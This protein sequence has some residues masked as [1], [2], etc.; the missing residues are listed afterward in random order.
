MAEADT[1]TDPSALRPM[2]SGS[3]ACS[4]PRRRPCGAI[5]PR[6]SFASSGSWAAP[7]RVPDGEFELLN[8]HDNLSD[9]QVPY[10]ERLRALQRAIWNEK[11]IRFEPPRL[12]ETTFQGGK[13]GTV[14]FELFPEG[15]SHPARRDAQRHHQPDRRPGFRRRLELAH[16]RASGEA[17]RARRE[18]TSGRFTPIA[19]G[20][21]G[22]ARCL[23]EVRRTTVLYI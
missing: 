12:L 6:R 11:V 19:R 2:R 15:R 7:M 13:N 20:G 10:P 21:G 8:D 23:D 17:R 9:E 22:G 14:T 3:S 18:G 5:S 16:D 4:T 1:C